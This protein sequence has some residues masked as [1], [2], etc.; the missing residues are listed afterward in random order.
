MLSGLKQ[1]YYKEGT[2]GFYRGEYIIFIALGEGS[3]EGAVQ[4]KKTFHGGSWGGGM[5]IFW[6]NTVFA[7]VQINK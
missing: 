3:W 1:I 2:L 4:T 6:K 5:D 7:V